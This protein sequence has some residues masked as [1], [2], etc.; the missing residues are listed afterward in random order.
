M[1]ILSK[2]G[3]G[4]LAA[5]SCLLSRPGGLWNGP[6]GPAAPTPILSVIIHSVT[7]RLVDSQGRPI[8]GEYRVRLLS[9]PSLQFAWTNWRRPQWSWF[10]G[11][12]FNTTGQASYQIE[13]RSGARI[14]AATVTSPG[15]FVTIMVR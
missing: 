10:P 2:L 8:D 6:Q 4:A 15:N 11:V 13:A 7:V 5:L 9:Y 14:G 12:P 3:F 1:L